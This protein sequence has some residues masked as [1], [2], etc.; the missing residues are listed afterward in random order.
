MKILAYDRNG[1]Y[2]RQ[3]PRLKFDD[4]LRQRVLKSAEMKRDIK[5]ELIL[6][7]IN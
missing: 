2:R 7:A 3:Q 1:Q 6:K 4:R 5:A